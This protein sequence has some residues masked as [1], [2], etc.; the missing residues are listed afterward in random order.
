MIDKSTFDFLAMILFRISEFDPDMIGTQPK[1]C[2]FRIYRDIRLS[3][4]RTKSEADT[5]LVG[6]RILIA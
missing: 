3:N 4:D 5:M 6:T 2:L 1:N